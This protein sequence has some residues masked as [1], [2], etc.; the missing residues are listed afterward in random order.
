MGSY[1]ECFK[2][3]CLTWRRCYQREGV[4]YL[5]PGFYY[6]SFPAFTPRQGVL[7]QI[8]LFRRLIV[9]LAGSLPGLSQDCLTYYESGPPFQVLVSS[10]GRAGGVGRLKDPLLK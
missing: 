9:R 5:Y 7:L 6:G 8:Y 2:R 3:L 1:G 4:H 10:L